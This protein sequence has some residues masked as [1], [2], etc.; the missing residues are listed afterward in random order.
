MKRITAILLTALMLCAALSACSI[1]I[2]LNQPTEQ[3]AETSAPAT[4]AATAAPETQPAP[5]AAPIGKLS[6]YVRDAAS[7][8]VTLSDGREQVYRFPEILLASADA[9]AINK[10]LADRFHKDIP[11]NE[12]QALNLTT[13]DY[14]AYLNGST[15]SVVTIIGYNGGNT[16]GVAYNIDVQT[17]KRMDNEAVAAAYGMA[18]ST[19]MTDLKDELTDDYD[20]KWGMLG[21][22]NDQERAKTLAD[23]NVKASLLYIDDDGDL[24]ALVE[25]YA[26]VGGGHFIMQVEV[27]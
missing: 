8:T 24:M 7:S 13:L 3:P 14:E 12:E 15:L 16:Y 25:T 4:Q 23:E 21:A 18:Y 27:D 19:A 11:S 17:G 5:T 22:N 2:N 1:N 10:E 26:A 9:E 20:E 6:D